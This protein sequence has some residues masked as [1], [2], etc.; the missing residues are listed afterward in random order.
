[1][2]Y[3]S[4]MLIKKVNFKNGVYFLLLINYD[5]LFFY[6]RFWYKVGIVDIIVCLIVFSLLFCV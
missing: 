6:G 5:L 2:N 3:L 1:M 4:D